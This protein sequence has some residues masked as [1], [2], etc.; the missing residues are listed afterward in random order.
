MNTHLW[1]CDFFY[2]EVR[3]IHWR[4]DYCSTNG[5]GETDW[6]HVGRRMQIFHSCPPAQNSTLNGLK[7]TT[8]DKIYET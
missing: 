7:G 6:L 2:K 5:P 3:N 4:K 1:T 8:Q